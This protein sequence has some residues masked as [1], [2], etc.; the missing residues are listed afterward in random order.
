MIYFQLFFTDKLIN[1]IV[2]ETNRYAE[3]TIANSDPAKHARINKWKPVSHEE[4]KLFFAKVFAMGLVNKLDLQD[5]W[6]SDK[7]LKT[8]WFK[9]VM[10]RDRFLLILQ[11][12]HF[13]DNNFRIPRGQAF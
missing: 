10:N 13:N 11:M 1:K 8:P 5:Y 6:S 2:V 7:V 4:M 3:Q 12:I 9:M